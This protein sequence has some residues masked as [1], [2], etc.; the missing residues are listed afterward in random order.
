MYS[1]NCIFVISENINKL[2]SYKENTKTIL[3]D[4]ILEIK[5]A[6]EK[7]CF[8]EFVNQM[9]MA[10]LPQNTKVVF[11]SNDNL[12][13]FCIYFDEASKTFKFSKMELTF[14]DFD[15]PQIQSDANWETR[16]NNSSYFSNIDLVFNEIQN[17]VKDFSRI[18]L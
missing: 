15:K 3:N 2:N 8:S 17:E 7:I 9:K 16:E 6:G 14:Y 10:N 1:C 4:H 13:R 11:L 12:K 18:D 5:T